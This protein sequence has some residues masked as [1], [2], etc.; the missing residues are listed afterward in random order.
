MKNIFFFIIVIILSSCKRTNHEKEIIIENRIINPV[1][2]RVEVKQLLNVDKIGVYDTLSVFINR[3]TDSIFYMYDSS[4]FTYKGACGGIG[5]GPEDFQFPFF[6]S[7][8][9]SN[10]GV[11]N[12]YDVNAA[13]FKEINVK[14]L[15]RKEPNAIVSKKM[16]ALLIGSPD[17]HLKNDSCFI[18][19]IDSGSGLYFIYD[20]NEDKINWVEFPKILQSPHGDFTVMNMNR[21]T[22]NFESDKVVSAMGY[23][24]LLFLYNSE[25]E[26]I[27]TI[28]LG[29]DEIRPTVVDGYH[30]SGDNFICCREI[31]SSDKAVYVLEQNIRE[32]EF[33]KA[34]NAPS[35]IVVFDWNLKYLK[36]YLLPHYSLGFVYDESR[37][38]ILYTALNS[39]GGTDV[40]FFCLDEDNIK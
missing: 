37:N 16:P 11:I 6:L 34:D 25:N 13:A 23:Y 28:Q 38:R 8:T 4:D 3:G 21:I 35:R 31:K 17:L 26:L 36:T 12:L 22:L 39:E 18:G 30:I 10:D 2:H 20:S 7:R 15:F 14:K 1:T 29:Y 19:N 32:K 5:N 27:K 9:D 40:Y 24:N 33:E